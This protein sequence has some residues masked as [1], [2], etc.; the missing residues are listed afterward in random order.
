MKDSLFFRDCVTLLAVVNGRCVVVLSDHILA[1]F[2]R[3]DGSR[4]LLLLGSV[5]EELYSAGDCPCD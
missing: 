5:R 1:A 2:G 3:E 4:M